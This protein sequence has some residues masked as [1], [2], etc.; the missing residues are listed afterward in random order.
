[1]E[2]SDKLP[3]GLQYT[4]K[5]YIIDKLIDGERLKMRLG[6]ITK[7]EA[8]EQYSINVAA[9]KKGD[10]APKS[11][12]SL[13]INDVMTYYY[14][15]HLK[16]LLSGKNAKFHIPAISKIIG[17]I[18][19]L[20][21]K[22][23]DI[24]R[25]KRIRSKDKNKR[26]E[27]ISMRTIQAELQNLN[28]A[29]NRMV[30]DY[31]LPKNPITRFTKVKLPRK[32]KV[33]LD[34]GQEFGS[35]WIQLYKHFPDRWKLFFLVCYETGMRPKEVANLHSE[36]IHDVDGN[37]MIIIPPDVEKTSFQDRRIPVSKILE[38]RLIPAVT[39]EK[40]FKYYDYI[41]AFKNAVSAAKLRREITAYALRRTRSTIWDS[42]DTG[43]ARVAL[44]HV[45][46]DPH[47]ESYVEITN[48]RLFKLVGIELRTQLRLLK[49][50]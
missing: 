14:E 24:E 15:N 7:K 31:I 22:K 8:I 23:T 40:I 16:D 29:I 26:K 39:G 48:Q 43:A 42:L 10:F 38:K 33:L 32:R 41:K 1:M 13:T 5:S 37:Y 47:E 27:P 11:A 17:D 18:K 34:H 19:V 28:M 49:Q 21:L 30:D 50:V 4:G 35:E 12:R 44:G 45:P 9:F 36:W 20:S 46:I 6:E 25:Y 2:K 3:P